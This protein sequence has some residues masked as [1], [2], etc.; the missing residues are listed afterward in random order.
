MFSSEKSR[1]SWLVLFLVP[2]VRFDHPFYW[3]PFFLL[4]LRGNR[5]DRNPYFSFPFMDTVSVAKY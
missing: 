2:S 5:A 4:M 1:I 3:G